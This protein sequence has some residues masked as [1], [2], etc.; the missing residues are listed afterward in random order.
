MGLVLKPQKLI[1]FLEENDYHFIRNKGS[2]HKIYSN[3]VHSV[4]IAVHSGKD[5]GETYIRMVLKETGLTKSQ[6]F[7]YLKR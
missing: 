1:G 5:F 6:L 4:P 7:N 2:S 3:G